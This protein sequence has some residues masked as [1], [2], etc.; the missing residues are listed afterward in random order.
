MTNKYFTTPRGTASYPKLIKPDT[1]FNPEG[2]YSVGLIFPADE[3]S[4]FISQIEENFVDEFGPKKLSEL[5][6]PWSINEDGDY[7]FKF[8]S[9]NKPQLFDADGKAIN[10]KADIK[11]GSGSVLKIKGSIK[12]IMVQKKY[13]ATLYINGVQL[14]DLV[15]FNGAGFAAE[16]GSYKAQEDTTGDD[17]Q[18]TGA[19]DAAPQAQDF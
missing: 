10:P 3:V 15:E 1:K 17:S 18:A 9:A 11:L 4:D 19:D 7:L 2:V 6:K 14:L 16:E 13:Y 12:P 5:Q 8:K